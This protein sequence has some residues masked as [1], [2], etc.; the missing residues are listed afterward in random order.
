[1]RP[2]SYFEILEHGPPLAVKA[3]SFAA[4]AFLVLLAAIP[5]LALG[6]AVVA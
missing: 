4:A 3:A 2:G 6:A 1:M 5:V